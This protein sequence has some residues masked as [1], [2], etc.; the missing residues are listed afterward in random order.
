MIWK[1]M[2]CPACQSDNLSWGYWYVTVIPP[3]GN[4][5]EPPKIFIDCDS[6]SETVKAFSL[7]EIVEMLDKMDTRI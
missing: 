4:R 3:T 5:V 1:K 6:C 7:E 2:V